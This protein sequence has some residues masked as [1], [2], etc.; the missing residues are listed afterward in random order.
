MV[1]FLLLFFLKKDKWC[2]T[3]NLLFVAL[4]KLISL[5]EIPEEVEPEPEEDGP[6]E[7]GEEGEEGAPQREDG[8]A[9]PLQDSEAKEARRRTFCYSTWFEQRVLMCFFLTIPMQPIR[10]HCCRRRASVS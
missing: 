8:E 10:V 5:L 9:Q 3:F 2:E 7:E 4:R 6:K 1:S